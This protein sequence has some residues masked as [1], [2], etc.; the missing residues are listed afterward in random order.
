MGRANG[1]LRQEYR[2]LELLDEISRLRYEGQ[3]PEYIQGD[4]RNTLIKKF[5][6]WKG[7]DYVPEN[8]HPTIRWSS[9]SPFEIF[10]DDQDDVIESNK[11]NKL[12]S[13]PRP[14]KKIKLTKHSEAASQKKNE[15]SK[16]R[17]P[18]EVDDNIDHDRPYK[19]IKFA[20]PVSDRTED[21]SDIRIEP[22]GFTWDSKNYSCS[23]DALFTILYNIWIQTP[24]DFYT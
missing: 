10:E 9:E 20:S 4:K 3:L 12:D 6:E 13:N 8:V 18:V 23:Y 14:T 17:R 24:T 5:Q 2:S 15:S 11:S 1:A 21:D 16:K 19:Q 22:I 7:K